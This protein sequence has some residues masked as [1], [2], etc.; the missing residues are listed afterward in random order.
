MRTNC[1]HLIDLK[2]TALFILFFVAT[3]TTKSFSQIRFE[4]S[5]IDAKN[6][7]VKT[8]GKG[9]AYSLVKR[10]E[11]YG[12]MRASDFVV[13]PEFE[14]IEEVKSS[15]SFTM[16]SEYK[17]EG[18][19]YY[20]PII[21]KKNGMYGVIRIQE[22]LPYGGTYCEFHVDTIIP[23]IADRIE[24]AFYDVN[25]YNG[26]PA[27]CFYFQKN[28]KWGLMVF[29]NWSIPVGCVSDDKPIPVFYYNKKAH[30]ACIHGFIVKAAGKYG[31]IANRTIENNSYKMVLNMGYDDIQYYNPDIDNNYL[32]IKKDGKCNCF[33]NI[34]KISDEVELPFDDILGRDKRH[35]LFAVKLDGKWGF[36]RYSYNSKLDDYQYK[37]VINPVYDEV[38]NI[39]ELPESTT[40]WKKGKK[41]RLVWDYHKQKYIEH[42]CN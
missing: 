4:S 31:I 10:G 26:H 19:D 18:G 27:H 21:A 28:G 7:F 1:L 14:E 33:F 25:L 38:E 24:Y 5:G 12:I 36:V 20:T 11:Y 41:Y 32:Y 29:N 9:D 34:D 22:T 40:V 8:I 23:F 35:G 42:K 3:G 37:W 15:W 6:Q 2:G 17:E 16:G 13:Q 39:D 30:M